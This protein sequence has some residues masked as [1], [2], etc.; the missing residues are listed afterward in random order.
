MATV[1]MDICNISGAAGTVRPLGKRCLYS[2]RWKPLNYSAEGK[3]RE[4]GTLDANQTSKCP[5]A[6][7]C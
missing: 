1:P 5:L 2:R 4:S 6:K 7:V 3:S